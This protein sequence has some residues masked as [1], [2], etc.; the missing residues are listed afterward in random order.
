MKKELG[1]LGTQ[2]SP[3]PTQLAQLL[4]RIS[5]ERALAPK[6]TRTPR[7]Q[8][9]SK[10]RVQDNPIGSSRDADA[11]ALVSQLAPE[12]KDVLRPIMR[13]IVPDDVEKAMASGMKTRA[14]RP[15]D[16]EKTRDREAREIV[17]HQEATIIGLQ[18]QVG[19]V[20]EQ[21]KAVEAKGKQTVADKVRA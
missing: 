3:P 18:A 15:V 2:P 19:E 5:A 10:R 16:Q 4:E 17:L 6:R 9:P 12:V 11:T 8:S 7:P 21:L 14:Q 20:R 13:D 1:T